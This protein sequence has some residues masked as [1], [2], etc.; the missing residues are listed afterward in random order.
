MQEQIRIP[1]SKVAFASSGLFQHRSLLT[2]RTMKVSLVTA[3]CRTQDCL[4]W[5]SGRCQSCTRTTQSQMV[6]FA[7]RSSSDCFTNDN[8]GPELSY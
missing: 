7:H 5:S 2:R 4:T 3:L 8:G 1:Y 6:L